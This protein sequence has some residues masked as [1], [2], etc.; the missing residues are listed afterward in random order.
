VEKLSPLNVSSHQ[1]VEL[2]LEIF[3]G[4][5]IC[6]QKTIAYLMRKNMG[7]GEV[8]FEKQTPCP[9]VFHCCVLEENSGLSGIW[10]G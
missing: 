4:N 3:R 6:K 5:M 1:R 9:H 7:T 2:Y 8:F 10:W